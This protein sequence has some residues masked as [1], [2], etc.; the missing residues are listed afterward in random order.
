MKKLLLT[1]CALTVA[2]SVFAQGTVIFNNRVTGTIVTHVYGPQAGDPSQSLTG[3][4]TADTPAGTTAYT[5]ALLSGTG[6]LAQLLAG[7][8]ANAS[9]LVAAS[10]APVTFRTG[11]AAGFIN[12]T[13][14]ALVGV[15]QDA[16][17]A[18]IRMA[19]WDNSSGQYGTWAAAETAWN[20]GLI[21]AG[22]SPAF[23]LNAIGGVNNPSPNLVGLQSFN[24]YMV[25]EPSTMALAGLGAAALLIFRRRK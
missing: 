2:V 19:V 12:S 14:A 17:T 25:P 23:N 21:A 1:A 18:T 22:L 15:P 10:T 5:G 8:G 6:Y 11:A 4:T 9:T 13:T 16:A 3:N 20:S 24:I 7:N